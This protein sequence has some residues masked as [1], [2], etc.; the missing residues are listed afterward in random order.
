[1]SQYGATKVAAESII[2]A[3]INAE[4]KLGMLRR[5]S[6]KILYENEILKANKHAPAGVSTLDL[7]IDTKKRISKSRE[8]I[9]LSY[10]ISSCATKVFALFNSLPRHLQ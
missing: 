3:Q 4:C 9:S 10:P 2:L 7:S 1:M 5:E 6:R 8:T